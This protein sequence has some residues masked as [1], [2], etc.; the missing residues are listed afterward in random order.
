MAQRGIRDCELIVLLGTE[1]EDG[2]VV[3]S[4]E[5]QEFA[6][7]LKAL[8]DRIKRIEG[9][10]LVIKTGQVVTAY[11]ASKTQERR[12]LRHAYDCD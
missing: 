2:Y 12:L 1:V 11:H 10:R 6:R 8:L 4:K 7:A 9:K 3:R 5:V